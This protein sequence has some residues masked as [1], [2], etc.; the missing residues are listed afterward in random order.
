MAFNNYYQN[1]YAMPYGQNYVMPNCQTPQYTPPVQQSNIQQN[2]LPPQQPQ[3]NIPMIYG[4]IVDGVD[5]V[6]GLDIPIGTSF[7]LPKADGNT[8]FAKGW[9]TDGTTYIKE[10]Q[11]I[12]QESKKD[13]PYVQIDWN[14]KLDDIYDSIDSLNKKIDKMKTASSSSTTAMKKRK[15]E[16]DDDE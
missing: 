7:I 15:V 9:N 5:V 1:P 13:V 8:I 12:E 16:V 3:S 10:Y 6:K 4:K 11:L 14:E 2:Q